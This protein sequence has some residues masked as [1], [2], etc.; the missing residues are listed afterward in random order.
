[1]AEEKLRRPP[2]EIGERRTVEI[3]GMGH[4]G[5]GVGRI[6]DFAVFVPGA[7]PGDLLHIEVE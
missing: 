5:E 1:M 2:V 3:T 4:A 7:I 6:N